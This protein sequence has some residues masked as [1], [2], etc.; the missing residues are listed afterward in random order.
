MATT[1][2][3]PTQKALLMVFDRDHSEETAREVKQALSDYFQK[4][5]DIELDALWDAGILNQEKLDEIR[6]TDL[7]AKKWAD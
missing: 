7:H 1:T 6:K 5:L 3:T 2:F 4:K